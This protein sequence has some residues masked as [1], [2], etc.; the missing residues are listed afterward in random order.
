MKLSIRL[1]NIYPKLK[2]LYLWEAKIAGANCYKFAEIFVSTSNCILYFKKPIIIAMLPFWRETIIAIWT[3][4]QSSWRSGVF[5]L[6]LRN[7]ERS[8]IYDN[9]C[10][11]NE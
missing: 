5:D 4:E 3:E 11:K 10:I 9:H 1:I 2:K 7:F 6:G 8:K